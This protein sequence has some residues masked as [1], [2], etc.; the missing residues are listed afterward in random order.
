[1]WATVRNRG[2]VA[3]EAAALQLETAARVVAVLPVPA[4][5]PGSLFAARFDSLPTLPHT[6]RVR[7]LPAGADGDPANDLFV[8]ED[9]GGPRLTF[10]AWP[11][12]QPLHSGD[13]LRGDQALLIEARGQGQLAVAVDGEPAA[14][15]SAWATERGPQALYRLTAGPHRVQAHLVGTA[16]ELAVAR[17]D[18]EVSDRLAV[19]NLLVHP[20]PVRD[21]T[22]FT[23]YLSGAADVVVDVYGLSGRRARRL[24]PHPFAEGFGQLPWDGRDDGG[25]RLAAGSYLFVLTARG[26]DGESVR[27]RAPLAVI[28]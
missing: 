25:A 24:G 27:R 8:L 2:P 20:N 9:A 3:A 23:F 16:G 28:R 6:V 18:V 5:P 15:D 10:R 19:A 11:S 21:E 12:A 14:A 17:L 7:V 1:M 13:R 26:P 22:A 4:L